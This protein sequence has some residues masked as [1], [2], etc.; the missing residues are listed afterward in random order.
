MPTYTIANDT[1]SVPVDSDNWLYALARSLPHFGLE[2][3]ALDHLVCSMNP[4]GSVDVVVDVINSQSPLKMRVSSDADG[5]SVRVDMPR[6]SLEYSELD[7]ADPSALQ[8]PPR[9]WGWDVGVQSDRLTVALER[10]DQIYA[11]PDVQTACNAALGIVSNLV[12]A[13]A[14]AVLLRAASD[15]TL[16]FVAAFGPRAGQV[17][18]TALEVTDGIAGFTYS[19]GIALVVQDAHADGR[20]AAQIDRASGYRTRSLLSAPIRVVN[21]PIFGCLELL[22]APKGFSAEDLAVI[23]IVAAALAGRLRAAEQ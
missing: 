11:T 14:G 4:D 21:G 5:M 3:G 12:D 18:D 1:T 13:D 16:L 19:S 8:P 20:Y 10:S 7:E 2:P 17:L 23:R 9:T 15:A 6:S 22:N